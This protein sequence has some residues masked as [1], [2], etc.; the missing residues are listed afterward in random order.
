MNDSYYLVVTIELLK[1]QRIITNKANHLIHTNIHYYPH[2][3]KHTLYLTSSHPIPHT[4]SNNNSYQLSS[5]ITFIPSN[6]SLL[7]FRLSFT[8]LCS[9][10]TDS[11]SFE[12]TCQNPIIT[13]TIILS[14]LTHLNYISSI[15]FQLTHFE[16]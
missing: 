12:T 4:S 14:T 11:T 7:T 10:S 5:F 8:F 15:T 9:P 2:H 13:I 1:S 16:H 3:N 6:L